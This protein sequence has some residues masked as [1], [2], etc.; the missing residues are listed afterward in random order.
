M[1]DYTVITME[2]C[3]SIDGPKVTTIGKYTI[4]G[5]FSERHYPRCT[6]PAYK[7]SK[8]TVNF[9]GIMYPPECK[10]ILQAENAVCGWHQQYSSEPQEQEGICPRCGKKTVLVNAA[11]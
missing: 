3:S 4:F 8:R 2:M 10:H 11:V 5:L 7:F 6:C 9:G 1:F